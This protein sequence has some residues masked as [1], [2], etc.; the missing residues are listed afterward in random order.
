MATYSMN[1]LRVG[2]KIMMDGDPAIITDA[3][4]VKPG[5]GQAFVRI[6][7]KN[8]KT[9]RVNERTLKSSETVEGADV[10][11]KE[12]QYVYSDGHHWYFMDQD[13][14]EQIAAD[15]AQVG[16]AA[17]WIKEEDMCVVTL[18]E[19]APISV[20]SPTFVVREILETDPGV[21]GDT[22]S[23]GNKPATVAGGAVVRIPLFVQQGE[24]IKIDTRTGEYVSRAKEE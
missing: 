18:F 1:Q 14:Y 12:M 24:L 17:Q 23:G 22:S 20:Q 2:L 7:A 6:K 15:E 3:D 16:E 9:N 19:G 5:K 8:L 11:D 10:V 21:R 13:T 4:F